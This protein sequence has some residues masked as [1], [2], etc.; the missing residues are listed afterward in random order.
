V[1]IASAAGSFAG[2]VLARRFGRRATISGAG[3]LLLLALLAA[4]RV[5]AVPVIAVA[6]FLTGFSIFVTVPV[7]YAAPYEYPG[8]SHQVIAVA[9]SLVNTVSVG[10]S[11]LGPILVGAVAQGTGSL[12][13]ALTLSASGALSLFAIGFVFPSPAARPTPLGKRPA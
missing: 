1:Q 9:L 6:F 4:V 11:A 3:L 2:P 13:L 5:D 7:I 12:S 10:S 8:V